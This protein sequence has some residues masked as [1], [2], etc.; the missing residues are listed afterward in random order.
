[1]DKIVVITEKFNSIRTNP[2]TYVRAI[3]S[4]ELQVFSKSDINLNTSADGTI[5]N[6]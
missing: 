6:S 2:D 4:E 5:Y 1:M 3:I